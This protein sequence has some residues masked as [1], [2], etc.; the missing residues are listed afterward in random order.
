MIRYPA[1][2]GNAYSTAGSPNIMLS[3]GGNLATGDGYWVFTWTGPGS[4]TFPAGPAGNQGVSDN[5]VRA[6][7][8]GAFPPAGGI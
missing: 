3:P 1:I 8:S 6:Y 2:Y 5:D 4:I 7:L